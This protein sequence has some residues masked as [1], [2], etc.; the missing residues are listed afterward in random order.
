MIDVLG[1]NVHFYGVLIGLGVWLGLQASLITKPKQ[2]KEID[3]AFVWALL[4]GVVGARIYHVVDYW[5]RYYSENFWKVFAVWEGGLGIW[6]AVIGA[7]LGL[8]IYCKIKKKK[9]LPL[10]DAFAVG[11]PVA[12]AVGRLGNWVNGE[13]VGK[14][15]EPLFAYEAVMNSV[16]FLLL[17]KLSKKKFDTGKLFGVYLI[18]Y[19]IIR[20]LLE[21]LRPNEIIW[22]IGEIPTATIFGIVSIA[23]GSAVIFIYRKRS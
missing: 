3:E 8:S 2:K 12:Q 23:L 13:L 5:N 21:R 1:I 4:L 19:G 7:I 9:V 20:I 17:W 14:N 11:A 6:G 10:L 18:G 22:R 16:L 15:G